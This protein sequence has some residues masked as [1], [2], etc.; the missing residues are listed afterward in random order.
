MGGGGVGYDI[1]RGGARSRGSGGGSVCGGGSGRGSWVVV[2]VVGV[3]VEVV[4][5]VVWVLV[6]AVVLVGKT[7]GLSVY[8]VLLLLFLVAGNSKS[9]VLSDPSYSYYSF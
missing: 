1:A 5:A 8:Q 4:A 3:V 7:S 9:L 6:E 2:L